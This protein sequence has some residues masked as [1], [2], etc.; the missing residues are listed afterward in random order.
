MLDETTVSTP[1]DIITYFKLII[2]N[3]WHD[4]EEIIL[5]TT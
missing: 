5:I 3:K 2:Q 4:W 1:A